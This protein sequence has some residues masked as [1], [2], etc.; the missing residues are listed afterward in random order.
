MTNLTKK[1]I[2]TTENKI[3]KALQYIGED[4][5]IS[6]KT[7]QD[8]FGIKKHSTVIERV[9]K[10][11]DLDEKDVDLDGQRLKTKD[12]TIYGKKFKTYLLNSEEFMQVGMS[13][14]SENAKL[15]R[16]II[17]KLL[18]ASVRTLIENK[19]IVKMNAEDQHRIPYRIGGIKVRLSLTDA[20]NQTVMIQRA[21]EGKQGDGWYFKTYTNL[22][23]KTLG[24]LPPPLGVNYRDIASEKELKELEDMEGKIA[25]MIVSSNEYYKDA[26]QTIKKQLLKE[27][28]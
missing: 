16:K 12:V 17:S 11:L 25:D 26:Y 1:Q 8:I 3:R 10:E 21:K 2:L 13:I 22:A 20:I 5:F 23:Y 18:H 4:V 6:T 28:K 9:K 7:I 15:Y 19:I 27:T 24:V 14:R